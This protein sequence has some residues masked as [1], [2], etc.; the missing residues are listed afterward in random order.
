MER[1]PTLG[2]ERVGSLD[3]AVTVVSSAE[4][5]EQD[6]HLKVGIAAVVLDPRVDDGEGL[7][8]DLG[9]GVLRWSGETG[10]DGGRTRSLT[11]RVRV[12]VKALPL[13][14][15]WRAG[16]QLL[17]SA[18]ASCGAQRGHR[19]ALRTVREKS[20]TLALR[21]RSRF[22]SAATQLRALTV[23]WAGRR[24]SLPRFAVL[25]HLVP[26]G[27]ENVPVLD[28]ELLVR[29]LGHDGVV[30][31]D[32]FGKHDE[33]R[34]EGETTF[35]SPGAPS[36]PN[37][38]CNEGEPRRWSPPAAGAACGSPG[39]P[40][41]CAV[42]SARSSDCSPSQFDEH[43]L[44]GVVVFPVGQHA[45]LGR[46]HAPR[47]LVHARQ[48]DA[49]LE[50]NHRRR[51]RVRSIAHNQERVDP[52]L[53]HR[54]A[55]SAGPSLYASTY[56]TRTDD[57][58]VPLLH[59]NVVPVEQ[60]VRAG[61][62]PDPLL[63]LFEFLQQAK[64]AGHFGHRQ[65]E[66]PSASLRL[67]G[68]GLESHRR[69]LPAHLARYALPARPRS[70]PDEATCREQIW[71]YL[72]NEH[73]T[74][75]ASSQYLETL[76]GSGP[77][78]ASFIASYLQ[79]QFGSA[80]LQPALPSALRPPVPAATTWGK[81]RSN[82]GVS[83]ADADKAERA[84]KLQEKLDKAK[85]ERAFV[86]G[87]GKVLVK[88]RGEQGRDWLG[89]GKSAR[90]APAPPVAGP[91]VLPPPPPTPAPPVD[92]VLPKTV[93]ANSTSNYS[94]TARTKLLEIKRALQRFDTTSQS[95]PPVECFCQGTSRRVIQ[96]PHDPA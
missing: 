28:G 80:A 9:M 39:S 20:W 78:Q 94:A 3:H 4:R 10:R 60:T 86:G 59:Q 42:S 30:R 13:I 34:Q 79:H 41:H 5:Q 75:R 54:L 26:H 88:D 68:L 67:D 2:L 71:P 53:V 43:G 32:R 6:V 35:Q 69:S 51:V 87:G 45:Q 19:A 7:L 50:R 83:R 90:S 21:W 24:G 89:G 66:A 33:R 46:I 11:S 70:P 55:P 27:Q 52:V 16:P 82:P 25:V 64:R 14:S 57:G 65:S 48:V 38:D 36:G 73:K 56:M 72:T 84:R 95:S 96:I 92:A 18:S 93:V 31:V 91:S 85:I 22:W 58:A 23:S 49:R 77:R 1:S 76:L 61:A 17:T 47:R 62:V 15:R 44:E 37:S 40:S 8:L 74:P 29:R 12:W 63:A 81:P